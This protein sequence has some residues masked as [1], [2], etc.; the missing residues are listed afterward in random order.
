MSPDSR[1]YFA[2][3]HEIKEAF[4]HDHHRVVRR[5]RK[6]VKLRY[7]R[8]TKRKRIDHREKICGDI[9]MYVR[10]VK[11]SHSSSENESIRIE[12]IYAGTSRLMSDHLLRSTK[13]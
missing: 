1:L 8:L 2:V 6:D 11:E 5:V 4:L 12:G 3:N 10:I 7:L 13:Q 9:T